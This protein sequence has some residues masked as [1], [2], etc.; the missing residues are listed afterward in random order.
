MKKCIGSFLV[1][2]CIIALSGVMTFAAEPVPLMENTTASRA[3]VKTSHDDLRLQTDELGRENRRQKKALKG[4]DTK[5]DTIKTDVSTSVT[6]AV[7]NSMSDA[8]KD[9]SGV[10]TKL[11]NATNSIQKE[12]SG[13]K[14]LKSETVET[15]ISI[16]VF[17]LTILLGLIGLGFLGAFICK[18][19]MQKIESSA[20]DARG[21]LETVREGVINAINDVPAKTAELVKKLEPIVLT[22]DIAGK[23]ITYNPPIKDGSYVGLFVPST[24]TMSNNPAETTRFVHSN[25]TKLKSSVNGV[26]TDFMAGKFDDP[27][28]SH[29]VMQKEVVRFAL[30]TGELNIG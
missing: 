23:K 21:H 14:D 29:S 11:E 1:V 5:I 26:L 6:A 8:K 9:L 16:W 24:A 30:A 25:V 28:N 19:I 27:T 20:M 13:I 7:T 15:K 12:L 17:G 18:S 22:F 3:D 4:L 2:I 10:T